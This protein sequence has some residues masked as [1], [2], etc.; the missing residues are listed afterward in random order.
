M[1]IDLQGVPCKSYRVW[2]CSV[3]S[4]CNTST[5]CFIKKDTIYIGFNEKKFEFEFSKALKKLVRIRGYQKLFSNYLTFRIKGA[6]QILV[7]KEQ[8]LFL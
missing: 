6:P 4:L 7:A 3:E 1:G 8:N 5:V 2:A